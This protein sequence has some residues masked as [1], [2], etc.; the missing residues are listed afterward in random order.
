MKYIVVIL[1]LSTNGVDIEKIRLKH[2]GHNCDDIANAWTDVNMKYYDER[3]GNPKLQ[4]WYDAVGKL[5]L[6]WACY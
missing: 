4:G 1:L 3:D 6:G 2:N 5:L